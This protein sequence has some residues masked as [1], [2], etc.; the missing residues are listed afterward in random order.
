LSVKVES[1]AHDETGE[2]LRAMGDMIRKLNQVIDGQKL[3]VEAANRGDF[4][5]RV[6]LA[7]LQGFQKEMGDGLNGLVTTNGQS[8]DD[9]VQVMRAIS[10]GDLSRTID[11]QYE[12]AF[13]QLK[14]YAN[15]TIRKLNQVI[16]GQRRVVEAANRGDFSTRVEL[17]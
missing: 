1:T 8:I 11:K 12:G 4:K 10:E 3:V 13:A 7:G 17:A 5:V 14:E 16:D 15:N 6:D 2:M 9:V